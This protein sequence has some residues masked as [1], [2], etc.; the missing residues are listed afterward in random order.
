MGFIVPEFLSMAE[1]WMRR[2]RMSTHNSECVGHSPG[3]AWEYCWEVVRA[4]IY[5]D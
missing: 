1:Q 3:E 2:S 4:E 5:M